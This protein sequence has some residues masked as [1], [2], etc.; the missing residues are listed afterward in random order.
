MHTL[1]QPCTCSVCLARDKQ[2]KKPDTAKLHAAFRR[3]I[4]WL[5]A[6]GEF[7]ARDIKTPIV[8]QLISETAAI[9][10]EAV[11]TQ[12]KEVQPDDLFVRALKQSGYVFSGFNPHYS[13]KNCII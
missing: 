1:L 3:I 5:H 2:I 7:R 6:M 13:P 9:F 11:D 8:R 12:L 4:E 10:N